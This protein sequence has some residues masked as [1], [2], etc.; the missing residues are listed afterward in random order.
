MQDSPASVHTATPQIVAHD[1]RRLTVRTIEF[2]RNSPGKTP[3]LR[4]G[5]QAYDAAGRLLACRDARSA[6]ASATDS[7]APPNLLH[8]LSLGGTVLHS[9]SVDSGR[10]ISLFGRAG[11]SLAVWDGCGQLRCNAFDE[12]LRLTAVSE[13]GGQGSVQAVERLAYGL[14]DEH[15]H[16]RCGRLIRHD[17]TAGTKQVPDYDL[18]GNPVIE[19]WRF[20]LELDTPDW[21]SELNLRDALLETEVAV[22]SR[23]LSAQGEQLALTDARQ[24]TRR[25]YHDLGGQLHRASLQLGDAEPKAALTH[26]SFNALGQMESETSG[27]GIVT[28]ARYCPKNGHLLQ[29]I[30]G[31]PGKPAIQNLVYGYDPIGNVT[32]IDDMAQPSVFFRNQQIDHSNTF[33]YDSLYQ[34]IEATGYESIRAEGWQ[35]LYPGY[36]AQADSGRLA[37]YCERY[38]YDAAG[39]LQNLTH[40]GAHQFS[41]QTIT[42]LSSNRSLQVQGDWV[43]GEQEIADGFDLNGNQ[44]ELIRGQR[45]EWGLRNQLLQVT[46]VSR[47]SGQSDSERYVYNSAS[48]RVRKVQLRQAAGNV[49]TLEVRYLPGL[50]LHRDSVGDKAWQIVDVGAGRTRVSWT[51]WQSAA[52]RGA[53]NVLCRYSLVDHLG[54]ATLELDGTANVISQESYYPYGGTAWWANIESAFASPKTRRYSGKEQDASGL[55]YYGMRYYAPWLGRWVSPDPA[56]EVDGLNLYRFV[57]NNP[58]TLTD[59]DGQAPTVTLLYGFDPARDMYLEHGGDVSSRSIMT[60]DLLN[61]GIGITPDMVKEHYS[62]VIEGF[63]ES[64]DEDEGME[65]D[66]EV[67]DEGVDVFLEKASFYKGGEAQARETLQSW[68][69]FLYAN[70]DKFDVQKKLQK[71]PKGSAKVGEFWRKNLSTSVPQ[72]ALDAATELLVDNPAAVFEH[73]NADIKAAGEGVTNWLF[74][75]FSKLGLDWVHSDSPAVPDEVQFVDIGLKNPGVPAEGWQDLSEQNFR[76]QRYKRT[77]SGHA[78]DPITY[79][80]RRHVQRSQM[81]RV[82]LL[83]LAQFQR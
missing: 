31:L 74:R 64:T 70:H 83:K 67:P 59:P 13:P 77:S 81:Q 79:S 73:G 41:Q 50:E 56:G 66:R 14:P 26:S 12:L 27:N 76:E 65:E 16:N 58:I 5:R 68:S 46:P 6:S 33:S 18:L 11:E 78:Y 8:T 35:R 69:D 1:P 2:H 38:E 37:N 49:R 9:E 43:P 36:T 48:E 4:V 23:Q 15:V 30:S 45:L 52:P 29:L 39:N 55:Y 63:F 21:P 22:T 82:K 25:F 47:D 24:N 80:E 57:R 17:D 60:I 19:H 40:S 71:Y 62:D 3:D 32:S 44:L 54:S 51:H 34:L 61:A 7:P 72:S 28:S 75:Q 53:E 42:S 10:R 20:L